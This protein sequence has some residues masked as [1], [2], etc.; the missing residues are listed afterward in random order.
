MSRLRRGVEAGAQPPRHPTTRLVSPTRAASERDVS[1]IVVYTHSLRALSVRVEC[2]SCGTVPRSAERGP[3]P[4]G[5][6]TAPASSLDCR[7][8]SS[9]VASRVTIESSDKAHAYGVGHAAGTI[10][11]WQR[12]STSNAVG[13]KVSPTPMPKRTCSQISCCP[14]S[15]VLRA[16]I[17]GSA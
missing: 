6:R 14:R 7:R 17:A 10:F 9:T 8:L 4:Y 1:R 3:R 5:T 2:V 15:R 13:R 12:T 11:P 16:R